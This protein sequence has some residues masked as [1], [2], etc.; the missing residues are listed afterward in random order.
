M[1]NIIIVDVDT[2]REPPII[3]EK[4]DKTP[5]PT[6]PEDAKI[7]LANDIRDLCNGLATLIQLGSANSLIDKE[8]A[9]NAAIKSLEELKSK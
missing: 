6:T 3:I 8:A 7:M 1:I 9:I 2:E 5:P 4:T